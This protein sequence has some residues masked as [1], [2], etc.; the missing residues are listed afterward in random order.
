M[1]VGKLGGNGCRIWWG[2][3]GFMLW[4]M[5]GSLRK[6]LMVGVWRLGNRVS[7]IMFWIMRGRGRMR[8]GFMWGNGWKIMLGV[9]IGVR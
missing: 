5:I 2:R 6:S 4:L 1:S 8:L 9:G 7:L 3:V